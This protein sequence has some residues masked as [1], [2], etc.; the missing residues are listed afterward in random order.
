[1]ATNRVIAETV[2]A[3]IRHNGEEP[4]GIYLPDIVRMIPD[5]IRDI[6][7]AVADQG[8]QEERKLFQKEFSL[9]IVSVVDDFDTVSLS[10]SLSAASDPMLLALPFPVV[11][12]A[13]SQSG[14]LLWRGDLANLGYAQTADGFDFYTVDGQTMYINAD[15]ELTGTVK[16]KS[17]YVPTITNLPKQF[18]G[19]L[20][21]RLIAKLGVIH[22][23]KAKASKK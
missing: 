6:V 3:Q 17:F 5:A 4:E 2:L 21:D 13:D 22:S 16:I 10:S 15:P 1:M 7:Q 20:V 8:K 23:A 19:E 14:E 12:H 18:E 11:K 9:S